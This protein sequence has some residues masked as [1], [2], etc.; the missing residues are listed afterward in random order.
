M[1]FIIVRLNN[2]KK[3]AMKVQLTNYLKLRIENSKQNLR[4]LTLLF[5]KENSTN[6]SS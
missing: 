5:Q 6:Y 4:F 3:L 1:F 2:L